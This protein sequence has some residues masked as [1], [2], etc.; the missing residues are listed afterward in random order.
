MKFL[1]LTYLLGSIVLAHRRI[2]GLFESSAR[3]MMIKP[4]P[5]RQ[6]TPIID[7]EPVSTAVILGSRARGLGHVTIIPLAIAV[8]ISHANAPKVLANIETG[9]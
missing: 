5:P 2:S 1:W 4:S 6:H 7:L 8:Y 9:P 3:A